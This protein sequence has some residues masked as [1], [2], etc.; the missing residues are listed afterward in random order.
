RSDC[1]NR[2]QS[3]VV[4]DIMS[5]DAPSD[6][7]MSVGPST[8]YRIQSMPSTVGPSVFSSTTSDSRWSPEATDRRLLHGW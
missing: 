5:T 3:S 2:N 1:P 4:S 7:T 8:T 6:A